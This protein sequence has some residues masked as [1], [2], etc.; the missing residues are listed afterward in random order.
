MSGFSNMIS[1]IRDRNFGG[2]NANI[3]AEP[4][5]SGYAYTKWNISSSLQSALNATGG[6]APGQFFNSKNM[7]NP[8][9]KLGENAQNIL[10]ATCTSVTPPDGRINTVEF[11]A[12]G[13][14]KYQVPGSIEYGN[15]LQCRFT[16]FSGLPVF[17]V[18]HGWA[19]YIRNNKTG[20]TYLGS[21]KSGGADYAKNNY[22]AVVLY[23]TTKP[24]GR[25]V[26]FAAAFSG[27]FPTQDPI[28]MFT[29]DITTVEKVELEISFNVDFVYTD[30]WVYDAAQA[31]ADTNPYNPGVWIGNRQNATISDKP[32]ITGN[33][34][35]K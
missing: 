35:Y 24:D 16:E 6:T 1:G 30:K 27:V 17:R 22:S 11:N 14:A 34:G 33:G 29:G 8:V 5:V 2:T 21:D 7:A 12:I 28:E 32:N 23:W 13:G 25:T 10:S 20:T 3:V 15:Q 4:Y 19:Q 31:A 26:E 18:I 9:G